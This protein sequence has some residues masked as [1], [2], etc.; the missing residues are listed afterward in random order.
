MTQP[1]NIR[2]EDQR[3]LLLDLFSCAGGSAVGYARAFLASRT[4]EVAA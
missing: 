1:T 3:P 2:R 4:L